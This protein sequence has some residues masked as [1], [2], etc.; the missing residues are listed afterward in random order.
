MGQW[1]SRG[2]WCGAVAMMLLAFGVMSARGVYGL[3]PVA[4]A[5]LVSALC[6][7]LAEEIV[8]AS[9]LQHIDR[10]A[11]PL[12]LRLS[13]PAGRAGPGGMACLRERLGWQ[14]FHASQAGEDAPPHL[15]LTISIKLPEDLPDDTLRVGFSVSKCVPGASFWAHPGYVEFHRRDG[16][17]QHDAARITEFIDGHC[18][19]AP[20]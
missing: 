3:R 20:P 15:A 10:A 14:G 18:P 2:Q 7:G 13:D 1:P 12:E 11:V 4:S 9:E 6:T 5:D 17:W 16:L 8:G 19:P